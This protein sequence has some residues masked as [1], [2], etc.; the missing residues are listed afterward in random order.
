MGPLVGLLWRILLGCLLVGWHFEAQAAATITFSQVGNDVQ[1]TISGFLDLTGINPDGALLTGT[2]KVRG[3][4]LGANVVIGESGSNSPTSYIAISGPQTIGCSTST[5][6]ASSASTDPNGPFGI[7]MSSN[8]LIVPNGFGSGNA[9]SA[10]STWNGATISSLGLK[11]GTYHYT[12]P[13]DSLTIIIPGPSG[14][15]P[16]LS[17]T[18]SPQTYT[19]SPIAATVSCQG[20]GSVSNVL[21]GGSGIVPSNAG[22]YAV[23]ANCAESANYSAV[24]GASAGN[25]VITAA[26]TPPTPFV[27]SPT[28]QTTVSV[29]G[30]VNLSTNGGNGNP[31]VT[32]TAVALPQTQAA[33]RS[34]VP[35]TAG[36]VCTIVGTVLTPTGGTGVCQVTAAQ[37]AYGNYQAQTSTFNITVTA[38]PS[39]AP[40]PTLSEWAQIMMMLMI[41]ATVG[42]Y[43]W[44]MNQR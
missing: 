19:G 31:V 37:G 15:I 44:R 16:T 9:F 24:T 1:A 29:G 38:A 18:N 35:R 25:F 39:P 13:R 22:N 11:S 8:R 33:A 30:S 2:S 34:A 21:Y 6:N 7:N 4:G 41:I 12:W 43:G 26:P 40:I 36:L 10:S 20:G 27:P 5:I 42:F 28:M 14:C 3:A 32:Y 23:T 17:L